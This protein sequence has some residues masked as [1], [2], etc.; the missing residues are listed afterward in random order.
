MAM[1][2]INEAYVGNEVEVKVRDRLH[3]AKVVEKPIYKYAG[4]H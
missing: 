1:L 4:K 3:K 2:N